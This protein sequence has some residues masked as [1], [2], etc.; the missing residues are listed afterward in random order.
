MSMEKTVAIEIYYG[1]KITYAMA[2]D[3]D[4]TQDYCVP[5]AQ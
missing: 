1:K 2:L 3:E 4:H 5:E